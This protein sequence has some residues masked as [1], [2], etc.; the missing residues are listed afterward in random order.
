MKTVLILTTLFI[1][2]GAQADTK[3]YPLDFNFKPEKG[4]FNHA[5]KDLWKD[6]PSSTIIDETDIDDEGDLTAKLQ[7]GSV[8]LGPPGKR[9]FSFTPLGNNQVQLDWDLNQLQAYARIRADWFTEIL[10]VTI[11]KHEI[12]H[13]HA[14]S[15][16]NARSI[17]ELKFIDGEFKFKLVS[18]S[19]FKFDHIKVE[20]DDDD[21]ISWF[22]E[23]FND[24]IKKVL[25]KEI[26]DYLA[27]PKVTEM[28]M[29]KIGDNLRNLEN[30]D[31]KLS[32]F[33]T[34]INVWFTRF[35]FEKERIAI[36]LQSRFNEADTPVHVCAQEM[37][38]AIQNKNLEEE[39]AKENMNPGSV[40]TS[41]KFI[42]RII[43]NMAT[44]EIDENNDGHPD[45]PLFCFGYKD[46]EHSGELEEFSFSILGKERKIKL[47]FW[48]EP[49]GKP[50]YKYEIL[51]VTEGNGVDKKDHLITMKMSAKVRIEN[52]GGYPMIIFKNNKLDTS[53][54]VK[55]KLDTVE[56]KGLMIIPQSLSLD[57]F[58]GKLYYKASRFIPKIRVPFFSIRKKLEAE[59]FAEVQDSLSK[60]ILV[61]EILPALDMK[62][63]VRS[64]EMLPESHLLKFNITY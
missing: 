51:K 38:K 39:D 44:Y 56:G 18:N 54:T 40:A 35:D 60:E 15:I 10:G 42:E 53:F 46:P 57:E 47:K 23:K 45:E 5:L 30:I 62:V 16:R 32:E 17:F 48:A 36:S 50:S 21:L 12:F 52:I 63:K 59:L 25:N 20:S 4:F 2:L 11:R 31:L 29:E 22:L 13:V 14:N 9:L 24:N 64:Y 7:T 1:C 6:I 19:G 37:M 58:K 61:D 28:I 43:Q 49:V 55:F 3:T 33:A 26:S 27:G 34:N 8:N 41:H